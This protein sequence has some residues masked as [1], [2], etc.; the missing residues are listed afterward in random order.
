MSGHSHWKQIKQHKGAADQKRAAL[1]SKL[2]AA[3]SVA[4]RY[5]PNPQFNIQ[6]RAAVEKAKANSVPAENIERAIKRSNEEKNFE[7]IIVEA[8]GP[9]GVA[10][11]IEGVTDN[12]NRAIA[13]I[14]NILNEQSAK[15]ANPG[16]VL[17]SF[18]E[19]TSD[20]NE[21]RPKFTQSISEEAKKKITA[22]VEALNDHSD[23]QRVTTNAEN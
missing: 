6:L 13:E 21:W 10:L 2:L 16:S 3:I 14:K 23:V 20:K 22:L 11:V 7:E 18:D 15:I 9:E 5:D 8:Y 4:A 17:W 1:F 12:T 19:P